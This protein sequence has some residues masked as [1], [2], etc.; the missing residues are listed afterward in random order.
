MTTAKEVAEIVM[1]ILKKEKDGLTLT[2]LR[3]RLADE[4]HL[5]LSDVYATAFVKAVVEWLEADKKVE[6]ERKY[7]EWKIKRRG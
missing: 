4:G 2:Q 3:K 5:N 6:V 1:R 7:K